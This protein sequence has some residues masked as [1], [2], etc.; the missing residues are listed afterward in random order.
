VDAVAIVDA[1]T[2]QET[3]EELL[4]R[5]PED[6]ILAPPL[7]RITP[8]RRELVASRVGGAE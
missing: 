7:L 2:P 3:Y 8:D 1:V 5:L 6:Q 4:A